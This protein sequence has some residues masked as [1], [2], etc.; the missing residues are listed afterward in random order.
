[1]KRTAFTHCLTLILL[2]AAAHFAVAQTI[3]VQVPSQVS[4]GENFRLSYVV[5]TQNVDKFRIGDVPEGL[6]VVS[7][8]YTSRSSSIQFVN[9]HTSTSSSITYTYTLY[10]AKNGTYTIPAARAEISGKS[11]SSGTAK[12]TVS[13][14][15]QQQSRQGAPR[16]HGSGNDDNM[17]SSGTPVSGNDLFI[18]VSANKT[19]V[20]EQEP[21]LLTY[22]VFSQVDLTQ[23]QGKMPDLTGFHT[24][25]LPLPQQKSFKV[26][27]VDGKQYRTVTWSQYVMYPQMTGKLEIPS[28]T[29]EGT[30]VQRNRT[31]DPFEAFFNGG[32]AYTEVKRDVKAPAITIQVDPLP[33]RPANFSGGVGQFKLTATADKTSVRAGE[34]V[35]IRVTVSGSGNL[36]LI[37]QP[38]I[39][40]PKDFDSYDPK[41]TDKTSLTQSGLTG[42]MVYEYLVVPRNQG[43]Y[44]IPALQFVYFDPAAKEYKTLSAAPI[45]LNVLKGSGKTSVT[46][47]SSDRDGDIR[48]LKTGHSA[49]HRPG[50]YVFGSTAHWLSLLLPLL[51]FIAIVYIFRRRA[52]N[53]A[54]IV[55]MKGRKANKV[56]TRRLRA[57]AKLMAQNKQEAFYNEVLRALWGYAGDKLNI[58]VAK[59]SREYVAEQ[60]AERA[61]AAELTDAFVGA[62]DECEYARYAPGEAKGKMD[63]VYEKAAGAITKIDEMLGQ[64]KSRKP[65]PATMLLLAVMLAVPTV[66]GAK[67]TK[68]MAD[69][70]YA[71]GNYQEAI[72]E[73]NE[74]LAD[75]VSAALYFNLGNAYYRT[76]NITQA[77]LAYERALKLSPSDDDIRFNLQLARSRTADKLTPEAEVFFVTWFKSLANIC[78]SDV[79]TRISIACFILMLLLLLAYLFA[80]RLWMVKTGFYAAVVCAVLFAAT[81]LLAWQQKRLGQN[82]DGAIIISPA[83]VVKKTPSEGSG[84][85]M[86]LHEGTRVD[87][88]DRDIKGWR[89]VRLSDGREGW[90]RSEAIEEI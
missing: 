36:K 88:T 55:R 29:F 53:N 19:R 75:G 23:L 8:P 67:A 43:K 4:C 54:N 87:I 3:S 49:T 81:T 57:A 51:A 76:E 65:A 31:V 44:T 46:D 32:S 2:F 89:G 14:T 56:A 34:P 35:T 26:E 84:N 47:F 70:E 18:R 73:Y 85:V 71:K 68:Q 52:A 59:Q 69:A 41:T 11:V 79:W 72:K 42:S 17:A 28:I 90:L 38:A 45:T 30:V 15:A 37:K 21:I 7:G 40:F 61:I 48:P 66:S 22:K 20:F 33:K 27:T 78:H 86:T 77:V 62:I 82:R 74:V 5:N 9:G 58:P 60:F 83:V 16:M 24:Q 64:R 13:G 1:M 12:V 6:D 25:E 80:P 10:A 50:E 63:A 39:E